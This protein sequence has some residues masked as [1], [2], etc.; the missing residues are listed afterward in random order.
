MITSCRTPPYH[1][2]TTLSTGPRNRE[3]YNE[4]YRS[5]IDI[6][7]GQLESELGV[8]IEPAPDEWDRTYNVDFYIQVGEKY[9][10]IQIKPIASGLAL[11][12]YQWVRMHEVNH[13]RFTANF[14]GRVFFVYS[15][16]AGRKK[17][18]YNHEVI[19]EIMAEMEKL[20]KL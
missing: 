18:I 10:G 14:G 4:G 16:E 7:Y 3:Y 19:N 12:D 5:E 13:A 2:H 17:K 6:V 15:V 8:K 20:R 9:I 1:S 11:N